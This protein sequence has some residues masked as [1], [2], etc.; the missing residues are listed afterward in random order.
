MN[1]LENNFFSEYIYQKKK[2]GIF[3]LQFLNISVHLKR[4]NQFSRN[5]CC[6]NLKAVF[7]LNCV[8]F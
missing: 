2:N 7:T 4:E 3:T 8:F 1:F 6:N 5:F